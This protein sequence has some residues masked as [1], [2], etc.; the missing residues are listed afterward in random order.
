MSRRW[1]CI[2]LWRLTLY[3]QAHLHFNMSIFRAARAQTMSI[4]ARFSARSS[5]AV[6]SGASVTFSLSPTSP[7]PF[8]CTTSTSRGASDGNALDNEVNH[9]YHGGRHNFMQSIS[10]SAKM[11]IRRW[12]LGGQ[13]PPDGPPLTRRVLSYLRRDRRLCCGCEGD[14]ARC[15]ERG[16]SVTVYSYRAVSYV[17]HVRHRRWHD[18]GARHAFARRLSS[19]HCGHQQVSTRLDLV[20]F[21]AVA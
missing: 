13:V 16:M 11:R 7:S 18:T 5:G 19:S 9:H 4:V 2:F 6:Y 10:L 21:R 14:N 20:L 3:H 8:Y 12:R 15:G 17:S 1:S